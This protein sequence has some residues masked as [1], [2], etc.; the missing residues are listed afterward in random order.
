MWTSFQQVWSDTHA[1]PSPVSPAASPLIFDDCLL[2]F[3]KHHTS[4]I[5]AITHPRCF[6]ELQPALLLHHLVSFNTSGE[7]RAAKD[8]GAKGHRSSWHQLQTPEVLHRSFVW[9]QRIHIQQVWS[10]RWCHSYGRLLVWYQWR[11]PLIWR[12]SAATGWEH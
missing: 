9:H 3:P 8:Q 1:T 12:I 4:Q 10:W 7:K 6:R 2:F 11:R 5:S